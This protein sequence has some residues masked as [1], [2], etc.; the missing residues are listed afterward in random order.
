MQPGVHSGGLP[1][2]L[3]PSRACGKGSV[4]LPQASPFNPRAH[5]PLY[6]IN[7][8]TSASIEVFYA[9]RTMETFGRGGAGWFCWLRRRGFASDGRVARSLRA[10]RPFTTL[11]R[12]APNPHNSGERSPGFRLGADRAGACMRQG[13]AEQIASETARAAA[14]AEHN[15]VQNLLKYQLPALSGPRHR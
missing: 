8:R 1:S 11:C 13:A 9:D 2:R 15:S 14:G 12:G 7:P 10:T 3:G 4:M 6:D 5:E